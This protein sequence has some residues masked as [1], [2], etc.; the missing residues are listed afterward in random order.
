MEFNF[1]AQVEIKCSAIIY[2]RQKK[3][4]QQQQKLNIII[5]LLEVD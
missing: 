1:K 3:Q 2:T 4:Q 5:L